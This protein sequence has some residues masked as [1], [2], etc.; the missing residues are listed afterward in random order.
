M[1]LIG[2][3][4]F[5]LALLFIGAGIGCLCTKLPAHAMACGALAMASAIL[6]FSKD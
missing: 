2:R 5:V 4:M 1:K 6:S 3:M